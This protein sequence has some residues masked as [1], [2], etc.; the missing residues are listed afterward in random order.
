MFY[1]GCQKVFWEI[2]K[3]ERCLMTHVLGELLQYNNQNAV[4]H[5][6]FMIVKN[7]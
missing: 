1:E 5:H 4:K 7:T 6:K 3:S 2:W